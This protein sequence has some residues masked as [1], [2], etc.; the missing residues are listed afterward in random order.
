MET[1]PLGDTGHESSVLTF[2]AIALN[3]LD[4]AAADELMDSVLDAGV[5][6]VDVA[7]TYGDAEP[8]LAPTLEDRRDEV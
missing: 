2:G 7:P 1:R 5:N 6:H 8:K 4:Q 3:Y